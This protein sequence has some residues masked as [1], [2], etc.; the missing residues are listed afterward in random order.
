[1]P[2]PAGSLAP[3]LDE[4]PLPASSEQAA[5]IAALAI[6]IVRA[7]RWRDVDMKIA[8]QQRAR[9]PARGGERRA[10]VPRGWK[11][12]DVAARNVDA[13]RTRALLYAETFA[14]HV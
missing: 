14:A 4:P 9:R 8:L 7:R 10:Y 6:A 13:R 1:M 5:R 12:H 11:T 2:D 3:P